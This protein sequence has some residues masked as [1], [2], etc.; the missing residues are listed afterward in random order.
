[1]NKIF[2][3]GRLV[4]DPELRKTQQDKSVCEFDIA[5]NRFG[6]DKAD[7][8]TCIAWNKLA[9]NLVTYQKKGNL[10]AVEGSSQVDNYKN[11]NG[12]NRYKHY[13]LASNVEY[14]ESKKDNSTQSEP[15]KTSYT[16]EEIDAMPDPDGNFNR[17]SIDD[18]QLPF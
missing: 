10:I 8:L 5:V 4:R 1:M 13:I 18:S 14:L 16:V 12:E 2:L 6:S 11:E 17:V 3:I 9:E 7:F 15:K